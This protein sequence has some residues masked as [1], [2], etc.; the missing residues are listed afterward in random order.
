VSILEITT[1]LS[2]LSAA[3]QKKLNIAL[4]DLGLE[5]VHFYAGGIY[6]DEADLA[7]LRLAKEKQL[8][9]KTE[10]ELEAYKLG[11]LSEARAKARAVEGYTYQEERKYDVLESAAE[12]TGTAGGMIGAGMGLGMGLGVM[13]E[14]RRMTN[15]NMAEPSA[16]A[17]APAATRVCPNCKNEVSRTAKFCPECGNALPPEVKFCA[18]CGTKLNPGAKF[19]PECGTKV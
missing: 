3:M 11:V 2:D 18:E 8:E 12:N 9:V 1:K 7:K 19:C 17:P 16:P 4:E 5:A 10:V 15:N 14:T 6:A 13:D